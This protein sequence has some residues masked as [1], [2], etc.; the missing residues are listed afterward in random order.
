VLAHTKGT[1]IK[2]N[3]PLRAVVAQ[4]FNRG[5]ERQKQADICELKACLVF[6]VSSRTGRVT[7]GIPCLRTSKQT[8]KHPKTNKVLAFHF[9]VT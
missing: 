8:N 6:I 5:S 3:I 1:K 2:K 4:A 9:K 7:Q